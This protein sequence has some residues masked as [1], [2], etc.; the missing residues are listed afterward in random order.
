MG[1]IFADGGHWPRDAS[2][3]RPEKQAP[4]RAIGPR[5]GGGGGARSAVGPL[6]RCAPFADNSHFEF[7]GPAFMQLQTLKPIEFG[8]YLIE[9][10]ALDEAQLL[11]ALA[12]QWQNRSQLVD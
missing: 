4:R 9:K 6:D 8:D 7:G 11:D 5:R 3:A 2:G 10:K 1:P 12:D